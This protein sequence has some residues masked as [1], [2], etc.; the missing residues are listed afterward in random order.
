MIDQ[1]ESGL[2]QAYEFLKSGN[3]VRA[4]TLIEDA[5]ANDLENAEVIFAL[6]CVNFWA[7]KI[8]DPEGITPEDKGDF[9]IRSWKRFISF[10]ASEHSA[11]RAGAPLGPFRFERCMMAVRTG[12]FSQALDG[13]LEALNARANPH[14]GELYRKAGICHKKLGAYETALSFLSEASVL[15]PNV[16]S[17]VAE[18]ADCYALCGNERAAKVLFRDA[19]FV[20]AASI[21]IS[22]LDCLMITRLVE[23]V[24]KLGFSGA[25]LLEWIPVYGVLYGVFN[26]KREL[27]PHEVSKLK[28]AIFTLENELKEDSAN[29]AIIRP[30]LIN[31]YFWLIDY[32]TAS[33]E[34]RGSIE[35]PLRNIKLLDVNIYTQY[36]GRQ[37][38]TET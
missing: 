24:K 21:D 4:K 26:I 32:L 16:P 38:F 18:M 23:Q 15:L 20:D 7:D 8:A 22:F 13:F 19:F 12:I 25:E 5:L 17:I 6:R 28:Q 1:S 29:A 11:E 3:T 37:S 30:K 14:E 27:R 34:G 36:A 35:E 9:L 33:K 2:L 10:T 31:H